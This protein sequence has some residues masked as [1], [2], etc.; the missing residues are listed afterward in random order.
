MFSHNW[1]VSRM[2]SFLTVRPKSILHPAILI[3]VLLLSAASGRQLFMDGMTDV[4]QSMQDALWYPSD[5]GTPRR[6][7]ALLW[8]TAPVRLVG[9]LSPN[10]EVAAF[11]FGVASYSQIALPLIIVLRSGLTASVRFLLA[12]LFVA[13]T[14]FLANFAATELLFAFGLTTMFVVYMLDTDRDPTFAKRLTIAVLLLASYEVVAL[15]NLLL[16][17]GT[18][19]ASQVSAGRRRYWLAAVLCLALPFQLI[20]YL[21]EPIRPAQGVFNIFLFQITG[22]LAIGLL[23]GFLLPRLVMHRRGTRAVLAIAC[24]MLPLMALCLPAQFMAFRTWEFQ[25]S[26]PSRAFSAGI[27]IA[28]ASVPVF[29]NRRLWVWP[30][31]LLGWIGARSLATSAVMSLS[32]FYGISI[33]ASFDAFSYRTRLGSELSHH[34]GLIAVETCRFCS[35]PQQYGYPNLS[36][37]SHWPAYS[38]ASSLQN[39]AHARVVVIDRDRR[40]DVTD[41]QIASFLTTEFPSERLQIRHQLQDSTTSLDQTIGSNLAKA[42]IGPR[43]QADN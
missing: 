9:R 24:L 16:A 20:C 34:S 22:V 40:G 27:V 11:V 36:E 7:F 14:I 33:V 5:Q 29:L 41:D 4:V 25:F 18:L 37:P 26:Y 8:I 28:I 6:F 1:F 42:F 35:H 19:V 43:L 2:R 12:I 21:S 31:D 30:T 38:M 39:E 15:S 32:A 13:G 23:A 17:F 10:I 3:L